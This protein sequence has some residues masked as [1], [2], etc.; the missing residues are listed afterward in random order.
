MLQNNADEL[1]N[2]HQQIINELLA[3][4][5]NWNL[6]EENFLDPVE[7]EEREDGGVEIDLVDEAD[8]LDVIAGELLDQN[9]A[10]QDQLEVIQ[11]R[12]DNGP[13]H[14]EEIIFNEVR[15][16]FL[17]LER[18]VLRKREVLPRFELG[19]LDSESR[20]LTVTP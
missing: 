18:F 2:A 13:A 6:E 7:A 14:D 10:I 8:E 17:I 1:V 11:Q 16:R 3:V 4:E 5:E 9:D 20:V 15:L 12:I 19:S